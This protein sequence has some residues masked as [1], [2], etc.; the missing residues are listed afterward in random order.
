MA[1]LDSNT[2]FLLPCNGADESTSFIDSRLTSPHIVTANGNAQIDTAVKKWGTGS[3][4]FDG[5]SHL[6][7]PDSVDWDFFGNVTEDWTVDFW[8]KVNSV[9]ATCH[10]FRQS[11]TAPY[12]WI[13][14]TPAPRLYVSDAID[15]MSIVGSSAL[16]N[17]TEFHHLAFIKVGGSPNAIYGIYLSGTQIGYGT[18]SVATTDSGSLYIGQNSA[19]G[20]YFVG[21]LDEIRFQKSN[22]FNASPVVGLTDTIVV[23]TEAYSEVGG[24]ITRNQS[25]IIM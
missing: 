18:G 11:P 14:L 6:S 20:L 13:S 9:S 21:S 19:G 3:C 5:A 25:I 4:L 16:P 17:T 2:K 12:W 23:P 1:G 24:I 15:A 7:V 8:I 22:Y 10:L